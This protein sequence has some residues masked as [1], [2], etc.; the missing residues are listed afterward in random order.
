MNLLQYKDNSAAVM[1][2]L[3]RLGLPL[4]IQ[5][6]IG[7]FAVS[8]GL[9][10][11]H[12]EDAVWALNQEDV[13]G[14]RPSTD[15]SQISDWIDVIAK[16]SSLL[17]SASNEVLYLASVAAVDLMNYR[18]SL[19]HGR[20]IYLGGDTAFF[21]RN[22]SWHGE[23]RKRPFGDAHIDE[24][25]LD[26]AIDASWVLFEVAHVAAKV[27]KDLQAAEGLAAMHANVRRIKGYAHELRHMA[28]IMRSEKN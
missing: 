5:L 1:D 9:F 27:A 24:N 28:A 8:W 3:T 20:L 2:R 12:L 19:I 13:K 4:E 18:H 11:S 25:L 16:G 6:R 26:L 17:T 14:R 23:E 22:T 21:M 15:R 7:T 10:E